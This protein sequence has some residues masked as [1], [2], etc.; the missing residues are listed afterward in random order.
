MTKVGIIIPDF[1]GGGAQ[2]AAIAQA[3]G[4]IDK[5]GFEVTL[6]AVSDVGIM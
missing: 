3:N 5:G 1:I 2:K 6:I 4:L